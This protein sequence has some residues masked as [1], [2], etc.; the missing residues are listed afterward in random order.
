MSQSWH[1]SCVSQPISHKAHLY[2]ALPPISRSTASLHLSRGILSTMGLMSCRDANWNISRIRAR[3]PTQLPTTLDLTIYWSIAHQICVTHEM[4]GPHWAC[5]V[6][7]LTVHLK[8]TWDTQH[9]PTQ[10]VQLMREAS[11][12]RSWVKF[13]K[14]R[15]ECRKIMLA[16]KGHS[17]L[18]HQLTWDAQMRPSTARCWQQDDGQKTM[19]R[20]PQQHKKK[21]RATKHWQDNDNHVQAVDSSSTG[22]ELRTQHTRLKD[23]LLLSWYEVKRH[24]LDCVSSTTQVD[25]SA[26]V[27]HF[28]QQLLSIHAPAAQGCQG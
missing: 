26:V 13:G 19:T 25:K 10:L 8:H 1:Q 18:W 2:L 5:L 4:I 20:K 17:A 9:P 12:A 16:T 28:A 3:P 22:C 6:K 21:N 24:N 11:G 7:W 27:S 23:S 14:N 15:V